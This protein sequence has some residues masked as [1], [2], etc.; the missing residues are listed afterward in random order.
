[1]APSA[2]QVEPRQLP[3]TK[4]L[5]PR[6]KEDASKELTPLQAISQG[7]CLPSV[8]LFSSYDKQRAWILSHMAGQ[9]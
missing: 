2:V 3:Q 7:M 8:P 4:Q 6:S 5:V 1:M 9:S